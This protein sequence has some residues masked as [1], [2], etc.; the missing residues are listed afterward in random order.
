MLIVFFVVLSVCGSLVLF[1]FEIVFN[2]MLA[3]GFCCFLNVG[4]GFHVEV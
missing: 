1:C 2:F 4:F 3:V